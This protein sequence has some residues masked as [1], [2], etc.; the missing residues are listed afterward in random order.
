M[1]TSG[2]PVV[3][4]LCD[5]CHRPRWRLL[6]SN[7]TGEICTEVIPPR[8]TD[9]PSGWV[10][11]NPGPAGAFIAEADGPAGIKGRQKLA[12]TG[13]R[14]PRYERVITWESAE[15]AYLAAVAAGRGSIG[16]REI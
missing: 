16:L 2:L 4:V 6:V 12:C 10:P 5:R 7:V 15:R 13:R 8:R 14:H 9:I 1:D 11:V 3:S